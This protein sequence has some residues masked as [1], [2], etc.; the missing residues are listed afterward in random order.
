MRKLSIHVDN[1]IFEA[2]KALVNFLCLIPDTYL[3]LHVI[4][5][6]LLAH[7]K[8]N[9]LDTDVNFLSLLPHAFLIFLS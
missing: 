5:L 4:F 3:N 1:E 2:S 6:G 7:V 9:S 8:V